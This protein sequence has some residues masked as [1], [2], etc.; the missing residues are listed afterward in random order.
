M[1]MKPAP[2]PALKMPQTKLMLQFFVVALD[3]P[4]QFGDSNQFAQ[5]DRRRKIGQPIFCWLLFPCGPLDQQPL[6]RMWF[7]ASV[8][9]M[10]RSNTNGGKE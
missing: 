8:V 6:L 2:V 10:G 5:R 9:A 7:L 3:V 1:M 4:A